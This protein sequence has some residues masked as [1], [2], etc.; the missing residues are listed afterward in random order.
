MSRFVFRSQGWIRPED[1]SEIL[2]F[3][4]DQLCAKEQFDEK[5]EKFSI[6]NFQLL[7]YTS[8]TF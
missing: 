1:V 4:Y 7:N 6:S 3:I 2:F 8:Y 5:R